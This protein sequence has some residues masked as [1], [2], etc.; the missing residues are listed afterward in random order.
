[1]KKFLLLSSL[2]SVSFI[3]AGLI[4]P[5]TAGLLLETKPS[6]LASSFP[7]STCDE[8]TV[9]AWLE[10]KCSECPARFPGAVPEN[11]S[12]FPIS[13]KWNY[14]ELKPG[15]QNTYY[16]FEASVSGT[17]KQFGAKKYCTKG[18]VNYNV[19]GKSSWT[20]YGEAE[21]TAS[22]NGQ[23]IN[24]SISDPSSL[25]PKNYKMKNP[26]HVIIDSNVSYPSQ[27]KPEDPT[28]FKFCQSLGTTSFGF[29][30]NDCRYPSK[31]PKGSVVK[32]SEIPNDK[33]I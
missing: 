13:A 11:G 17:C 4:C 23:N 7:T 28:S 20:L 27:P 8:N 14:K 2:F 24:V 6:T 5:P 25:I 30:E 3:H 10:S 19:V 12:E 33:N 22:H 31:F 15:T 21:W 18:N 26:P 32:K 1:M 9:R 29:T 16:L